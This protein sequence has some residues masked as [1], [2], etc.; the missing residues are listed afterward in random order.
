MSKFEQKKC[1][2]DVGIWDEKSWD[3][4]IR[5]GRVWGKNNLI[6]L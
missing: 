3:Q 5:A 1:F 6:Y 2:I 4:T